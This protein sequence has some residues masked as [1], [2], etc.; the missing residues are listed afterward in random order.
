MER[1]GSR[2]RVGTVATRLGRAVAELATDIREVV[3]CGL[4]DGIEDA[5]EARLTAL[6][7]D[8]IGA[9][10]AAKTALA[11][12]RPFTGRTAPTL[13]LVRAYRRGQRRFLRRLLEDVLRDGQAPEDEAA[14]TLAAADR[15]SEFVD[16]VEEKL[17]TEY[18]QA[19]K[20]W[21]DPYAIL[22]ARVRSV[23]G[24]SELDERSAQAR[25]HPYRLRQH[26]LG[27]EVWFDDRRPGGGSI[28]LLRS[29][30]DALAAAAHCTSDPLFV[31]FDESSACVWFPLGERTHVDLD[32][33]ARALEP[34]AGV[35]IAVGEGGAGLAGFR[36][37]HEQAISAEAVARVNAA[38]LAR[39]T[40]YH[41]IAPIAAM[42]ANLDA[43]RAWVAETLGDLAIDDAR[44]ATYRETAR[45]FLA[46]GRSYTATA[47]E[48][49]LHR[50]TAQYRIR[51]AEE[52]RGK[53]FRAGRLDVELALLACRWFGRAVL[54]P[55]I[56]VSRAG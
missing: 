32:A 8:N 34:F 3:D 22:A 40:P 43:A 14:A 21:L 26:H 30:V 28:A 51:T 47:Q 53:P 20:E 2:E 38:P 55:P 37:T 42:A 56:T 17:L 11:H 9:A 29:V 13:G 10:E 16:L 7:R 27:A 54:A 35:R 50:N 36:R 49:F 48:L 4:P 1:L 5:V 31:P 41:E 45:V 12:A 52:M 24:E 18:A 6:T 25:L 23:L 46:S 44:H 15:V 39:L 33:L 19:R